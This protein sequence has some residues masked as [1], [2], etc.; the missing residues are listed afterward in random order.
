MSTSIYFVLLLFWPLILSLFYY[1]TD[2]YVINLCEIDSCP[3]CYGE[4]LCHR[5][6]NKEFHLRMS[7]ILDFVYN[8]ISVKNVYFARF[9]DIDVV[10]KKLAHQSDLNRVNRKMID[11]IDSDLTR[12]NFLV[13]T[14]K[15]D[16]QVCDSESAQTF[17]EVIQFKKSSHLD[18][19]L[20]VNVEPL[21]MEVFH[22]N[23]GF[24]VPKVYGYCG[25]AV[26]VENCGETLNN[27]KN[28]D[29]YDR[30]YIAYEILHAANLF[31][32]EHEHFRLYLKDISPDNIVVNEETLEVCFV[33]LGHSILKRKSAS[34]DE[35]HISNAYE[36]GVY[37]FSKDSICEKDVSDHNVFSVCAKH[38]SK[39]QSPR[40]KLLI[41]NVTEHYFCGVLEFYWIWKESVQKSVY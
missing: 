20:S 12:V 29:W 38:P 40:I 11:T 17:L 33:D 5:I 35:I 13:N 10:I 25:R 16:F 28:I 14:V 19:L 22:K 21:L 26:I 15:R 6:E 1:W 31:V 4:D 36:D 18:T 32:F 30:A 3:V 27:F 23:Y 2:L 37:Q 34:D 24:P 7:S 9:N 41:D 39:S 8:F